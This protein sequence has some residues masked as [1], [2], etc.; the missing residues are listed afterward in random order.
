MG[1]YAQDDILQRRCGHRDAEQGRA[2]FALR[3]R[4]ILNCEPEGQ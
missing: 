4:Q 1:I 3:V 2:L